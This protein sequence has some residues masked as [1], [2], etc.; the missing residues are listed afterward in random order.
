M[1]PAVHAGLGVDVIDVPL[2][3]ANAQDEL[4]GDLLI[5]AAGGDPET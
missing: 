5:A 3:R 2:D 4:V 1:R